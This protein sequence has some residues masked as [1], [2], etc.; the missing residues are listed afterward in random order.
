MAL[1]NILRKAGH[2]ETE[3][4]EYGKIDDFPESLCRRNARVLL[5]CA[6]H[7]EEL[8]PFQIGLGSS[9]GAKEHYTPG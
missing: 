8:C 6:W 7:I 9:A 1:K 4:W 3:G 5:I 2:T